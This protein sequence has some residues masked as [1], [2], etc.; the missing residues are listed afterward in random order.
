[1]NQKII[2]ASGLALLGFTGG[3]AYMLVSGPTVYRCCDSTGAC[4][5][6]DSAGQCPT[7]TTVTPVILVDA[8]DP[9][10][11]PSCGGECEPGMPCPPE[12]TFPIDFLCCE[13]ASPLDCYQVATA[14]QCPGTHDLFICEYGQTNPDGSETCF[15]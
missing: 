13:M 15:P 5:W 14:N 1:M 6:A 8:C 11:G 4:T 10:T 2:A 3:G 12:D 7:G 9:P